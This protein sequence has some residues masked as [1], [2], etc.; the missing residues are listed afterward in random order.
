MLDGFEQLLSF[1]MHVLFAV[2][3]SRGNIKNY[4]LGNALAENRTQAGWVRCVNAPFV[5]CR[6]PPLA[7]ILYKS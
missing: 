2:D 5:V 4:F 3:K 6:P 1:L 7:N